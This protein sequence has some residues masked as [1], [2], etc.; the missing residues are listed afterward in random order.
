MGCRR[1]PAGARLG[2]GE[3][4]LSVLNPRPLVR[5]APRAAPRT[6]ETPG[7]PHRYLPPLG[8]QPHRVGT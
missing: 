1:V 7:L 6:T 5:P 2:L 3:V 8:T 4:S